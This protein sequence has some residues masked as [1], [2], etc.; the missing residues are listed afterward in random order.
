M[1]K[2]QNRILSKNPLTNIYYMSGEINIKDFDVKAQPV[3]VEGTLWQKF[4]NLFGDYVMVKVKE[5]IF[6]PT[7]L[8]CVPEDYVWVIDINGDMYR[9]WKE[10]CNDRPKNGCYLNRDYGMIIKD[11]GEDVFC[12]QVNVVEF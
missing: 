12:T 8:D 11:S 6:F 9:V 2:E 5:C 10:D 1:N 7:H 3:I 4:C